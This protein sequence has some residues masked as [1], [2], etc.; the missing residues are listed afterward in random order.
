MGFVH[1]EPQF[2]RHLTLISN[3]RLVARFVDKH[4]MAG[5]RQAERERQS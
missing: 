2:P 1:D 4:P 3:A 5:R